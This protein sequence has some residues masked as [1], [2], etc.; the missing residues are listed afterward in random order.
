[1]RL[2]SAGHGL[3]CEKSYVVAAESGGSPMVPTLTVEGLDSS[4]QDHAGAEVE[5]TEL[6]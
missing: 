5:I 4:L 6:F 2:K 3:R 1:M